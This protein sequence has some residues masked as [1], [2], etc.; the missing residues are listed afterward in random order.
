MPRPDFISSE[1]RPKFR[2][3]YT[4]YIHNSLFLKA[5]TTLKEKFK[6]KTLSYL[7]AT[8]IPLKL[9]NESGKN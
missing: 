3:L 7:A 9:I 4:V 8:L 5:K 2:F 6:T 1:K